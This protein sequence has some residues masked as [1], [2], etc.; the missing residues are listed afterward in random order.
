VANL[1]RL[2][3]KTVVFLRCSS[4]QKILLHLLAGKMIE[5]IRKF[6]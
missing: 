4:V 3:K 2:A 1:F 5:E 6:V